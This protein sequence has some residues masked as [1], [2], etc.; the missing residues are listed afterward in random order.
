VVL[1]KDEIEVSTL[2]VNELNQTMI[3]H[4]VLY[5]GGC[6]DISNEVIA[7]LDQ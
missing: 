1:E 7:L 2:G 6:V 5:S 3:T 4:K